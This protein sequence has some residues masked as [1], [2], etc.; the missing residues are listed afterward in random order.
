MDAEET[1]ERP[2]MIKLREQAANAYRLNNDRP[3]TPPA[4]KVD[5]HIAAS[6]KFIPCGY[7]GRG[8]TGSAAKSRTKTRKMVATRIKRP[9]GALAERREAMLRAAETKQR[10]LFRG[11]EYIEEKKKE[12]RCK[13]SATY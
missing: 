11:Q 2:E 4:K 10:E 12:W 1:G 6:R 8:K 5:A 3:V 13:R 9:R 7:V